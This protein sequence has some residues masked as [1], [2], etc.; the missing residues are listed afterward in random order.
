MPGK[1]FEAPVPKKKSVGLLTVR[2]SVMMPNGGLYCAFWHD[3][4][5]MSG[6]AFIVRNEIR[7]AQGYLLA[8]F[9]AVA[10]FPEGQVLGFVVC[11]EPP[12]DTRMVYIFGGGK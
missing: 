11:D 9:D 7:D 1:E 10:S 6:G 4:W 5:I 8:N 3:D 12:P 2:E